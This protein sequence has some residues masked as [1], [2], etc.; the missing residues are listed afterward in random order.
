MK[1]IGNSGFSLIEF[2]VVIAIIAIM[3]VG[4][5][6]GFGFLDLANASKCAAK[7][8]N[9]LTSLKSTN[10]AKTSTT[11]MH[12]YVYDDEYYILFNENSSFSPTASNYSEGEVV[13]NG[14]LKVF[15][16]NTD[17]T[18]IPGKCVSIGVRR[19][20]GAFMNTATPTSKIQVVKASD[21]STSHE[22]TLVTATGKHFID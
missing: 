19:K 5:V 13:G 7:I 20:D 11:Y 10:M 12:L 22:I 4:G 17:L 15:F 16:D 18:I 8:D 2:M 3:T 6:A 9:G 1:R 21:S 14:K